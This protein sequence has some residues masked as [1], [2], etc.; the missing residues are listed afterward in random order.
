MKKTILLFTALFHICTTSFAQASNERMIFVIDDVPLIDNLEDWNQISNEDI[1]DM[2]VIRNKDSLK[3]LG[4]RRFD[5]VTY[6]FTKE[7]RN[8]ADSIKEIPSLKQMT[9][10]NDAWHFH[11]IPY[12]G[13]YIDYYNSGRKQNEGTLKDGRLNGELKIYYQNGQLGSACNYKE[14]MA[15]GVKI[16]YYSNGALNQKRVL[17]E[18]RDDGVWERYFPNGQLI[19]RSTVKNGK[20]LDPGIITYFSTG[21]VNQSNQAKNGRVI[22]NPDMQKINYLQN[23]IYIN[24]QSG[25]TKTVIKICSKIIKI[26]STYIN[27]Y[28]TMGGSLLTLFRF[29]EA[30]TTFDKALTIE[31]LSKAALIQRARTRINK[32]EYGD[33]R[34]ASK[35]NKDLVVASKDKTAIPAEER[36]KICVDLLTGSTL[37]SIYGDRDLK[38]IRE[39]LLNYCH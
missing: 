31:P 15:D 2:T 34:K 10:E 12:S 22:P 32:F 14:G 27:A 36:E 20:L 1:A 5:G 30:I 11:N 38:F 9:M 21:K 35:N 17:K 25:D 16:E 28:I 19:Q 18:G 8:R 6:I 24:Q 23:E 39:S 4:F 3:L 37:Q 7:Y 33:G 26:D 13:K 29:D